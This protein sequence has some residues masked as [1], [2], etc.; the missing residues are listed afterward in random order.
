MAQKITVRF[1]L[2]IAGK[3][4]EN[5]TKALELVFDK[6]KESNDYKFIEGEII[7]PELE[8]KSTMY[9][10]LIEVT[11]KFEKVEK[12]MGFIIDYTP[13]SVEIE[14]PET[15]KFEISEFNGV[16]NDMSSKFLHM[17]QQLRQANASL[18]YLHK[19]NQKLKEKS[20]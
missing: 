11:L 1:M 19:E 20:E 4:V 6:I 10:G 2:Q 12:L 15:L 17:A 14:D 16:L 13:N 3:P 5:V 7:E 9:S 8:E 18:H